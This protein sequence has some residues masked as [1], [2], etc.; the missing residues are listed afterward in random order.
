MDPELKTK[1]E[2]PGHEVHQTC[3][4]PAFM[5]RILS[6]NR[7]LHFYEVKVVSVSFK[8]FNHE[9]K[10]NNDFGEGGWSGIS[11]KKAVSV[12]AKRPEPSI[13]QAP[14]RRQKPCQ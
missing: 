9:V 4:L 8:G 12:I 5:E 1:T 7:L 11:N 6:Q 14:L 2:K 3:D 10:D 13:S